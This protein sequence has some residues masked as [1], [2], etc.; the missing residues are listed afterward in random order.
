MNNFPKRVAE[1]L[2]YGVDLRIWLEETCD[3]EGVAS[4]SSAVTPAGLTIQGSRNA[5]REPR[6]WCTG[7]TPGTV[8]TLTLT[9]VTDGARSRGKEFEFQVTVTA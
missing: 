5:T 2:D 8:Y 4:S 1:V 7:G 3:G 6:T 9:V